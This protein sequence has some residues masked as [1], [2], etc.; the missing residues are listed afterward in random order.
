[1]IPVLNVHTD[2]C[3]GAIS[4]MRGTSWCNPFI[5]GRDGSREHVL[6]L[7]RM[8]AE[9]RLQVQPRWLDNLRPAKALMCECSPLPCHGHVIAELLE[10]MKHERGKKKTYRSHRHRV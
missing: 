9:W 6:S 1:M 2:D 8:Y 4:I 7:F 5:I 10:K 3:Y